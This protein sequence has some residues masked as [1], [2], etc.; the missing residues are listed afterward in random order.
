MHD[1]RLIPRTLVPEGSKL[2]IQCLKCGAVFNKP[3]YDLT[4]S[5]ID[6]EEEQA[7]RRSG[8][9]GCLPMMV[10]AGSERLEG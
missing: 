8:E 1:P 10:D 4:S 2:E 7:A 3:D 5:L 9:V 6:C